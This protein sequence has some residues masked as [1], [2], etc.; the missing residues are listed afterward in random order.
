MPP[1]Q[2]EQMMRQMMDA[3]NTGNE[4]IVD[5][6]VDPG[7]TDHTPFPGT[8]QG[9][10]AL[11]QQ[12]RHLRQAFPDAQFTIESLTSHGESVDYQWKMVGTQRGGL[13]G[14]PPT[15]KQVTHTGSGTATFRNGKIVEHRSQD[16]LGDLLQKL[17][18]PPQPKP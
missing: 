4:A 8:G 15:N 16:N 17:G 14:H 18:H 3:F 9:R 13:M 2:N 6:L 7:H 1:Q 5:Q 12:I 10:N 11:K